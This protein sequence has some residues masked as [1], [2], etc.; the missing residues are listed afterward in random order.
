MIKIT[1]MHVC[2]THEDTLMRHGIRFLLEK[3]FPKIRMVAGPGCPVCVSPVQDIDFAFQI[4]NKIPNSVL[5]SYGDMIRVP[6]TNGSLETARQQGKTVIT[7][8]SVS[9][10]VKIAKKHPHREI[11]FISPGFETTAPTTAIELKNKPPNNFF[12]LSSHRLTPP[13]LY[14]LS[15]HPDLD[16]QGF[17]LPGH[18]SVITG[19]DYYRNFAEE[20]HIPSAISG[21]EPVD[22]ILG[23]SSVIKQLADGLATVHNTYTR[24]VKKEG[25][26]I[27]K[28]AL[29]EV[30]DIVD[31]RWRAL[32]I[33]PRSG[34]ELSENYSEYNA[35]I[36]FEEIK[37]LVPDPK[38]DHPTGCMCAE[39][40]IGKIEPTQCPLFKNR[41]TPETPVGPCM[42]GLEGTCRI[43]A[44]YYS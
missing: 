27:A 17:I 37:K 19:S 30:F 29:E 3:E 16:I 33:I 41:C 21:F 26:P 5:V 43:R 38:N 6:G 25:N 2:G 13:A 24:A 44:I 8:Y 20:H 7:V 22:L 14:L 18:V 34:L 31:S 9:D 11:I 39:V 35:R 23:I 28:A 4:A 1:I 42:V 32:G 15:Q 40:V 36:K 10:A 12:V